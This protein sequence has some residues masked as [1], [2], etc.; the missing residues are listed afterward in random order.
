MGSSWDFF[1]VEAATEGAGPHIV[2]FRGRTETYRFAPP[3]DDGT[4]PIRLTTKNRVRVRIGRNLALPD[5]ELMDGAAAT[6]GGSF[7]T[8]EDRETATLLLTVGA[9]DSLDMEVGVYDLSTAV[10]RTVGGETRLFLAR[11]GVF[12][13][14]DDPL[15]A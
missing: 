4:S 15:I 2:H 6:A 9:G 11:L 12:V 7:L 10:L 14:A 8:I 1:P 13:L 3:Q 5:I